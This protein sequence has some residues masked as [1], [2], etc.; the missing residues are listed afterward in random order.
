[1]RSRTRA[2]ALAAGT[3]LV[4]GFVVYAVGSDG[5]SVTTAGEGIGLFA[6]GLGLAA[7]ALIP[8]LA[9][10]P[11]RMPARV[12]SIVAFAFSGLMVL[13]AVG[14]LTG[15]GTENATGTT[16]SAPPSVA[17]VVPTAS[18][19]PTEAPPELSQTATPTAPPTPAPTASPAAAPVATPTA[20]PTPTSAP[21]PTPVPTA[22]AL[23][24][25][26][27]DFLDE[28][29]DP[30]KSGPPSAD[31]LSVQVAGAGGH[32]DLALDIAKAPPSVDPV[33]QEQI[34]GWSLDTTGDSSPE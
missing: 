34:Y 5:T 17:V 31:I 20:V 1:M 22:A 27:G 11:R 18:A 8:A 2:L 12:V 29:G 9:F 4:A 28:N 33:S 30:V 19:S 25:A 14:G 13:A 7:V 10:W 24:D 23:A 21:T 6:I 32:L 26:Q 15:I 16:T 3:L